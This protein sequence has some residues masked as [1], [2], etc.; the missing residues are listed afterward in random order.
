MKITW[1]KN[2]L[3]TAI[4]LDDHEKEILWHKIR[5]EELEEIISTAHFTLTH[6]DWW[7]KNIAKEGKQRSLQDTIDAAAEELDPD[8]W[9]SDEKSKLDKRTDELHARY[10]K[11]LTLSHCGD[12]TCFPMSCP[13]C[14]AE[15]LLGINTIGGLNKYGAHKILA[16]FGKNNERT[17]DEA[18][19]ALRNYDP[20]PP[21]E[22]LEAWAKVGG[23]EQHVPRWKKEAQQAYEWLLE[24]T[25]LAE[26]TT[27]NVLPK[28]RN[29]Y[30]GQVESC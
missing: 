6:H 1:H 27:Y 23:W 17:F 18:L 29:G 28:I 11:E 12:C 3:F 16:A 26:L 2:P 9:C 4:E 24:Y 10:L 19:E 21:T 20:Q 15:V 14:H 22:N 25:A 7:N 8:Y 30:D 13:K 5:Q